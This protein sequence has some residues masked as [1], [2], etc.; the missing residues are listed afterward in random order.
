[1]DHVKWVAAYYP[2]AIVIQ[3]VLCQVQLYVPDDTHCRHCGHC[4]Y[5]PTTRFEQRREALL[6]SRATDIAQE[7]KSISNLPMPFNS[8]C[9]DPTSTIHSRSSIWI[10]AFWLALQLYCMIRMGSNISPAEQQQPGFVWPFMI[11]LCFPSFTVL[12][13]LGKLHEALQAIESYQRSSMES[14][15][16]YF[17]SADGVAIAACLGLVPWFQIILVLIRS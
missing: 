1:M 17:L 6:A 13:S 12:T 16:E 4:R 11:I 8:E 7:Q 15:E 9:H 10:A 5:C 2:A 3:S 14:K